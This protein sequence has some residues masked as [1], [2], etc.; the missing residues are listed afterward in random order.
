M[1]KSAIRPIAMITSAAYLIAACA[2]A[3]PQPTDLSDM[4]FTDTRPTALRVTVAGKSGPI[5]WGKNFGK[6]VIGR[7]G[8]S[9][10][11]GIYFKNGA[12]GVYDLPVGK[13]SIEMIGALECEGA[14]FETTTEAPAFS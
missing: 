7:E 13:Y 8:S 12:L 4:T 9:D 11:I 2:T 1:M 5:L 14:R 3:P 10:A 6:F